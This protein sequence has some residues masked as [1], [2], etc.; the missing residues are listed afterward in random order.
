MSFKFFIPNYDD[1][2]MSKVIPKNRYNFLDN[3]ATNNF[4][5]QYSYNLENKLKIQ[6]FDN[7]NND[8]REQLAHN[9]LD[10]DLRL[11]LSENKIKDLNKQL[12][13]EK[14]YNIL[15]EEKIIQII[16]IIF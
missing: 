6:S 12:I 3:N 1:S 2:Y 11:Q 14:N 13:E 7:P 9:P 5:K 4:R 10:D 15:M 8:S 16:L